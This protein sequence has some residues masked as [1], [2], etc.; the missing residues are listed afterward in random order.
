MSDPAVD[1]DAQGARRQKTVHEAKD[2]KFKAHFFKQPTFCCHCS[3]LLWGLNKQ[4]FRCQECC[5]VVH[6]RCHESVKFSC[7]KVD[8][9]PQS[10]DPCSKHKFKIRTFYR[11]TFCEHCGSLIYGLIHQG[12]KCGTCKMNFHKRCVKNVPNQCGMNRT[13]AITNE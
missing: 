4:G 5:F 10:E 3:G 12:M 1:S 2:H 13:P 11:P 6:K 7:P 9:G 8:N